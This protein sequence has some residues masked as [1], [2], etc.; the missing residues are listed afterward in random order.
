M[1]KLGLMA[2]WW[3][4][5]LEGIGARYLWNMRRNVYVSKDTCVPLLSRLLVWAP[6]NFAY[7]TYVY[8]FLRFDAIKLWL[9][10]LRDFFKESKFEQSSSRSSRKSSSKPTPLSRENGWGRIRCIFSQFKHILTAYTISYQSIG[11]S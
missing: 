5:I 11:N 7:L 8:W 4:W 3:K 6:S 10:H 1:S 2:L 9:Y